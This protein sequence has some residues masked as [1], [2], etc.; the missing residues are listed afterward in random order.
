M[1]QSKLWWVW[2]SWLGRQIVALETKGSNPFTHPF[3]VPEIRRALREWRNWQTRQ[4]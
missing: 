2:P 1:E 3:F 4:T